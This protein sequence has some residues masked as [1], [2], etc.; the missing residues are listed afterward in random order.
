MDF[1]FSKEQVILKES[2]RRF[3]EKECPKQLVRALTD[4]EKEVFKQRMN[5]LRFWEG[6]WLAL[7]RP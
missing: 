3:L 4:D 5:L 6:L 2:A 7:A 1:D